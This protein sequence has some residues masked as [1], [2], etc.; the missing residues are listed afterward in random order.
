MVTRSGIKGKLKS[1]HCAHHKG[2]P[3]VQFQSFLTQWASSHP[4]HFPSGEAGSV[5][6]TGG[7]SIPEPGC[8]F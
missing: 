7:C 3:S 1:C 4:G 8:V 5:S 6:T 2:T